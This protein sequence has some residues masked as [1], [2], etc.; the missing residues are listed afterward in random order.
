MKT[1]VVT[2]IFG[3][4]ANPYAVLLRYPNGELLFLETSSFVPPISIALPFDRSV[5]GI[6]STDVYGKVQSLEL[7]GMEFVIRR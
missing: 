3:G 6:V 4:D 7:N 2:Q 5:Y 1:R